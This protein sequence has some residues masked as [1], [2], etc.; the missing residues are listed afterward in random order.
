MM[1]FSQRD[2]AYRNEKLPKSNE[3][4]NASGCYMC[5]IATLGQAADILA[6][7]RTPGAFVNGGLLV[8]DVLAKALE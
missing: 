4:I 1:L 7:M 3:T 2:P 8:S 5:S 6:F